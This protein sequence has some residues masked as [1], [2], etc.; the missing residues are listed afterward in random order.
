MF[1]ILDTII[2]HSLNA[3]LKGLHNTAPS[4]YLYH[5]SLASKAATC[6]I[7]TWFSFEECTKYMDMDNYNLIQ[8]DS[9][10]DT[11]KRYPFE[12]AALLHHVI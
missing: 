10:P 3:I 5:A 4:R 8:A 11:S 9:D 12:A 7:I 2:I 1:G 6:D